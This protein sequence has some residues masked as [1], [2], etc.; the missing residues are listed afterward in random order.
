MLTSVS[1]SDAPPL[2]RPAG[3][4][5]FTMPVARAPFGMA[6]LPS[7]STGSRT[8][9]EKFCPG[10]LILEP[11]GSSST[12]AITVSA[13]TTRGRGRGGA[14]LAGLLELAPG[15]GVDEDEFGSVAAACC[16]SAFFWH[17]ANANSRQSAGRDTVAKRRFIELPPLGS[18]HIKRY[19]EHRRSQ[20]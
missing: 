3:L 17:P 7:T 10:V 11:T 1:S 18:G 8:V 13:G 16:W 14:S 4:A 15:S 5:F 20:F 12:T 2:K 9:A 19:Y 6:T